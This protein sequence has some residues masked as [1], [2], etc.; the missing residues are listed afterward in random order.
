MPTVT[1]MAARVPSGVQPAPA[2]TM[3]DLGEMAP[4]AVG[5]RVEASYRVPFVG[6][7]DVNGDVVLNLNTGEVDAFVGAGGSVGPDAG[8]AWTTGPLF[9]WGLPDNSG[10]EGADLA[11][12]GGAVPILPL[13]VNVEAEISGPVEGGGPTTF[14]LGASPLGAG[15][16][17]GGLYAGGSVNVLRKQLTDLW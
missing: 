1:P 4:D 7:V 14:Y 13:G 16:A 12:A 5:W 10:L 9:V 17:Q 8:V 11:Y 2:L 3:G 15:G 6:G